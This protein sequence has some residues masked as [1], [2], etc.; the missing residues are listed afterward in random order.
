MNQQNPQQPQQPQKPKG[1]TLKEL[2]ELTALPEEKVLKYL[3]EMEVQEK[4]YM[5]KNEKGEDIYHP[6]SEWLINLEE[7]VEAIGVNL[8]KQLDYVGAAKEAEKKRAEF[9]KQQAKISEKK[10]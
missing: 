2:V 3:K 10:K 8:K 1:M 6:D 7:D 4:L 9:E 5:G